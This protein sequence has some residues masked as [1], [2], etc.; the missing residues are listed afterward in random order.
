VL[1]RTEADAPKTVHDLWV[2][3]IRREQT[4][5]VVTAT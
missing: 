1:G 4:F 3:Q 2:K 5:F